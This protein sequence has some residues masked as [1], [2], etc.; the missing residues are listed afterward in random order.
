MTAVNSNTTDYEHCRR[1]IK[2]GSRSFYAASLLLPWRVRRPAYSLYAFCRIS[3]DAIDEPLDG[4][5]Q[6]FQALDD[7]H[8]RLDAVYRGEPRSAAVDRA[9]AKVVEEHA[10]PRELPEALLDGFRWDLEGRR[11]ETLDDLHAYAA[12]VAGAV[13]AMMTVL[14][15][16]R[17]RE[18]LAR[19][20]DLGVAMQMTNMARDI[21]EDARAGRVYIPLEWFE[22]FQIKPEKLTESPTF[23]PPIASF[24]RLM[25]EDA[26]TLYDRAASGI[27][28]LPLDC[29]PAI[30]AARMIY[31]EIGHEIGRNGWNSV[32]HRAVVSSG[33][34]R[35][36]LGSAVVAATLTAS[37]AE[38]PPLPETAYL[39][40]AA[41]QNVT[42]ATDGPD[43]FL[44]WTRIDARAGR[45][46]ELLQIAE[47]RKRAA[48][49][50]P[51]VTPRY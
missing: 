15:G 27:A 46:V 31:R 8:R 42:P 14:M 50:A 47:E 43:R 12:R 35:T 38:A 30:Q 40:D 28:G 4:A 22:D 1:L 36:L 20:C 37:R 25:V 23:S 6:G 17:D 44:P 45:L 21:G 13:G 39:V 33:R 34:K 5:D 26:A 11:Y 29:R 19:A 24:A 48:L 32:D 9:F 7:L 18:T 49:F 2:T 41:A 51:D 3:D 16:R 10:M